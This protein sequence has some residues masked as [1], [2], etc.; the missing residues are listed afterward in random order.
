MDTLVGLSDDLGK[1]DGFVERYYSTCI[2]MYT[3]TNTF[4]HIVKFQ[5]TSI[6]TPRKANGNLEEEVL[7]ES[8][9][10]MVNWN[11]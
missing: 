11:F 2:M 3:D 1:L 4:K 10:M 7:K 9:G 6:P 8:T 5:K